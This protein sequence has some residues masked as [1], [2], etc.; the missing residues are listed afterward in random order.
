MSAQYDDSREQIARAQAD[1]RISFVP[2]EI[3]F[4]VKNES[5]SRP[6]REMQFHDTLMTCLE[7][8]VPHLI[9]A[10][11]PLHRERLITAFLPQERGAAHHLYYRRLAPIGQP[12]NYSNRDVRDLILRLNFFLG[13][14][15]EH[16]DLGGGLTLHA[17]TPN[18]LG[19]ACPGGGNDDAPMLGP[20]PVP[21]EDARPNWQFRFYR[22]N[23]GRG[24]EKLDGIVQEYR[25]RAMEGEN[26]DVVVAILDT[27]PKEGVVDDAVAEHERNLLL[28][29]IDP[30]EEYGFGYGTGPAVEF[31]GALTPSTKSFQHL[32]GVVGS[33]LGRLDRIR[34]AHSATRIAEVQATTY[35]IPD[36]GL[37]VAGIIKDIAPR[38]KIHLVRAVDDKGMT[39]VNT[40]ADAVIALYERDWAKNAEKLIVSLSV[41]FAVPT[42]E[43]F[44]TRWRSTFLDERT[45]AERR[46]LYDLL[47][48]NLCDVTGFLDHKRA[49]VVSAAG[50]FDER[51]LRREEPRYPA[52][53][54]HVLA[55][56]AINKDCQPAVYSN[57]AS[58]A[59][60]ASPHGIATF[61]GDVDLEKGELPEIQGE[62]PHNPDAVR[63]IFSARRLP[64]GGVRNETG[65]VYWV[66]TSFA[67]PIIAG[68]A[69][70]LW[71][72][73]DYMTKSAREMIEAVLGFYDPGITTTQEPL[74]CNAIFAYQE[75]V[76]DA[77]A[78]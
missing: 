25:R 39:D 54:E 74:R 49:L 36:H 3:C 78:V 22:A 26:S 32:H 52:Q 46:E 71:N 72:H 55:V 11:V 76:D 44:R 56:A 24:C 8:R 6:E 34:D 20:I 9:Q 14:H 4:V 37:F 77:I 40:L 41:T 65:W 31:D 48:R 13:L 29:K 12:L 64:H 35:P 62:L 1:E 53:C 51:G 70:V 16:L 30:R 27:A 50:N 73:D 57:P 75:A 60:A 63:G 5:E 21:P 68:I 19:G 33:W 7:Q 28:Q 42:F 47:S 38:A 43:L 17:V 59:D 61:G 18:W 58:D 2:D 67:T 10:L 66:G 15:K 45:D 69:A 23:D